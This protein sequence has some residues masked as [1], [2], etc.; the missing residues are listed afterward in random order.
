MRNLDRNK[1]RFWYCLYE[2]SQPVL[3]R[4]GRDTGQ[5]A[6]SYSEPVEAWGNFTNGTGNSMQLGQGRTS[7]EP[8]GIGAVY[9]SVVQIEGADWPIDERT[10]LFVEVEPPDDF[11]PTDVKADYAVMRV[12]RTPNQT[13]LALKRMRDGS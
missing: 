4:A 8:F 2:G 9:S 11:V 13:S 6:I 1:R 3:D 12:S 7:L 10:L 5:R